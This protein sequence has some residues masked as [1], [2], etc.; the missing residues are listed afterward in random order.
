MGMV[1]RH[2]RRPPMQG[3]PSP[4]STTSWTR[5]G[6]TNSWLLLSSLVCAWWTVAWLRGPWLVVH[7]CPFGS[8]TLTPPWELSLAFLCPHA[9]SQMCRFQWTPLQ[10]RMQNSCCVLGVS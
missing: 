7:C 5:W 4:S 3:H 6:R 1:Q 8:V 10:R 2:P 9:A